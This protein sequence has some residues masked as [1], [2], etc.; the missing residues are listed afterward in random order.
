MRRY[1][2]IPYTTEWRTRAL[3]PFVLKMAPVMAYT[4]GDAM[5]KKR[6]ADCT[7]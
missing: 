7:L 6:R 4:W 5:M 3:V 1:T 2:R